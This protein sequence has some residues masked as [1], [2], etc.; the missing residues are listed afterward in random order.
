[1]LK[2]AGARVVARDGWLVVSSSGQR[3]A[4]VIDLTAGTNHDYDPGFASGGATINFRTPSTHAIDTRG[5]YVDCGPTRVGGS[6]ELFT[7]SIGAL[8]GERY[9]HKV[10]VGSVGSGGGFAALTVGCGQVRLMRAGISLMSDILFSFTMDGTSLELLEAMR[11]TAPYPPIGIAL[12]P[13]GW[14]LLGQTSSRT[15]DPGALVF[16]WS[17]C[18]ATSECG[19]VSQDEV[20]SRMLMEACDCNPDATGAAS[21]TCLFSHTASSFRRDSARHSELL[22]PDPCLAAISAGEGACITTEGRRTYQLPLACLDTLP[23]PYG[24]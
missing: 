5:R 23:E 19:D 8:V 20:W 11:R 17:G 15:S 24:S 2:A 21:D 4:S 3:M 18:A 16:S 13:D 14:R 6:T 1:V 10:I 22:F 12:A 9:E 7:C